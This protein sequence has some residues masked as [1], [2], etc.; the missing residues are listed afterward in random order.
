MPH[1]RRVEHDRDAAL[2]VVDRAERRDRA[3]ANPPDLL[4]QFGRTEQDPPLRADLLVHALEVD[5]GFLFRAPAG[6]TGSSCP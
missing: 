4:Q 2:V 1:Q 5:D 3:R 6:T